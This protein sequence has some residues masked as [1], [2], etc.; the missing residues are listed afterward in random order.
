M[1]VWYLHYIQLKSFV[2][3]KT[4]QL[5]FVSLVAFFLTGCAGLN[6]KLAQYHIRE[7]WKGPSMEDM[8]PDRKIGRSTL[9]DRAP[10]QRLV[11]SDWWGTYRASKGSDISVSRSYNP[12]SGPQFDVN[13]SSHDDVNYSYSERP[14][15]PQMVQEQVP[16]PR[17]VSGYV[18]L[19]PPLHR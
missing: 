12:W 8:A 2:C 5:L 10:N 15:W 19:L 14:I 18:P 16:C 6:E 7:G 9:P 17:D 11:V 4:F 3:M 1:K 13:Y